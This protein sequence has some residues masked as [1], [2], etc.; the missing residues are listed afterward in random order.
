[1]QRLQQ[2]KIG[3]IEKEMKNLPRKELEKELRRL[4]EVLMTGPREEFK[5]AKKEIEKLWNRDPKAFVLVA[6]VALPYL[7][8][9]NQIETDLNKEAFASGLSF[10]FLALADNHFETLKNFTLQ[11]IQHHNGHVREAIR[12]TADWLFVSLSSQKATQQKYLGY[13][14]EVEALIDQYDKDEEMTRYINEMK[15]SINKTLQKLWCR[16]TGSRDYQEILAETRPIP[17]Q[18]FFKRRE[19]EQEITKMLAEAKS[20][21]DLRDVKDA[22]FQ[23]EE[24]DDMMGIIAMFDDGNINNLSTILE[25]INDA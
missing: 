21:F 23:E 10:F 17:S 2:E 11:V 6:P 7:P 24:T 8:K 16:L 15:P 1:M 5:K 22:I 20:D 14:K 13:V 18:I 9:F 12:K 4:L 25:I 19:L 3:E